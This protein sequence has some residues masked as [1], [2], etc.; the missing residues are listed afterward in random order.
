MRKLRSAYL[1]FQIQIS[2]HAFKNYTHLPLTVLNL[3]HLLVIFVLATDVQA[4][5]KILIVSDSTVT[6]YKGGSIQGWGHFL[7]KYVRIPVVNLAIL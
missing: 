5:P 6:E 7:G 3:L 4:S 1:P 2:F